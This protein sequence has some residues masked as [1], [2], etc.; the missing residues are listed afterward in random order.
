MLRHDMTTRWL[1]P[2]APLQRLFPVDLP[3]ANGFD[4][5]FAV[6]K[7]ESCVENNPPYDCNIR[8]I[9]CLMDTQLFVQGFSKKP[10]F[11]KKTGL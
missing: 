2:L 5:P 10:G 9:H 3:F 11:P 8:R 4:Q 6:G 1:H 7:F